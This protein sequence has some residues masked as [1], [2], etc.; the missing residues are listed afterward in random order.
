MKGTLASVKRPIIRSRYV[1]STAIGS[2]TASTPS[3]C[4]A[5]SCWSTGMAS[6]LRNTECGRASV[7]CPISSAALRPT[8]N[9]AASRCLAVRRRISASSVSRPGE[10]A[11]SRKMPQQDKSFTRRTSRV[12]RSRSC[13]PPPDRLGERHVLCPIDVDDRLH[14]LRVERLARAMEPAEV[15]AETSE[16]HGRPRPTDMARHQVHPCRDQT[17]GPLAERRHAAAVID[18]DPEGLFVRDQRG[19]REHRGFQ[20]AFECS[21]DE[22]HEVL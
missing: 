14:D 9:P 2:F 19:D 12:Y 10:C 11:C 3:A 4:H 21:L 8:W 18:V 20:R 1:F 16:T 5:F 22:T 6:Q 13:S 17:T 7:R 15:V